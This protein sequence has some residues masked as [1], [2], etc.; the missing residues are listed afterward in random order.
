ML[1]LILSTVYL[2][3]GSKYSSGEEH[4]VENEQASALSFV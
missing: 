4:Q 1:V 2:E 3:H